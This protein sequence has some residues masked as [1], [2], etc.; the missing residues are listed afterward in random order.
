LATHRGALRLEDLNALPFEVAQS[1]SQLDADLVLGDV[2]ELSE[3]SASVLC[4]HSRRLEMP[5]LKKLTHTDLAS[6]LTKGADWVWLNE[7]ED[8]SPEIAFALAGNHAS[9]HLGGLTSLSKEC[10][11][12]FSAHRGLLKLSGLA[13]L[14]DEA[15]QSLARHTG[16]LDLSGVAYISSAA[17]SYLAGKER[18]LVRISRHA[19][20]DLDYLTAESLQY[21][22]RVLIL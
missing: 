12:A 6:K 18:G 17:A 15:A 5:N 22:E 13:V 9:L 11:D 16:T 4:R 10:A 14:S 3:E 8:I 19:L 7:L 1:F 2:W 20:A 21:S